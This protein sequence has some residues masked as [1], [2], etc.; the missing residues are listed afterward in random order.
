MDGQHV[1]WPW[2]YGKGGTVKVDGELSFHYR[3]FPHTNQRAQTRAQQ[4]PTDF[5]HTHKLR[6][7]YWLSGLLVGTCG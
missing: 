3:D 4:E 6:S 5:L 7:S 1:R 2:G